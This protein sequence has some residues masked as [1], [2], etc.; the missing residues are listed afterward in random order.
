MKS[1]IYIFLIL[2]LFLGSCAQLTRLDTGRTV[3]EGNMEIGG[4]VTAYGVNEVGSPDLGAI[5]LPVLGFQM[6]Y[7]FTDRI[8]ANFSLNSSGNIYVNPKFQLVG[9]Q[10]SSFALSV[11]PGIDVQVGDI[12]GTENQVIFRPHISSILSFHQDEWAAFLEP[13][14]IY[15]NVTETH[16]AGATIG[17]EY[18]MNQRTKL[19]LGYS[20][21]PLLGTDLARGSN[22]Y[23][24][25]FGMKR[26]IK[27]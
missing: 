8:D 26:H 16:F 12:D 9:D 20:F 7:G 5:A 13:K 18:F 23:N 14:Y 17:V 10:E 6:N 24:I 27:L 21:F 22:I 4:Y 2:V 11:L 3:G 15:Q 19:S 25:G 1:L